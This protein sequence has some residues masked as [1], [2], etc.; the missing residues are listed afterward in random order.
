[1]RAG[2]RVDRHG[3]HDED[4]AQSA[5]DRRAA[6][7]SEGHAKEEVATTKKPICSRW[8]THS[9]SIIRLKRPVKCVTGMKTKYAANPKSVA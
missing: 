1:M 9:C 5:V 8:W 2:E 6:L 3:R 7:Q 4:E